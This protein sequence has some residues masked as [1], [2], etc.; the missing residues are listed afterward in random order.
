MKT[1]AVVLG[2]MIPGLAGCGAETAPPRDQWRI[3]AYTD[4][5]VP[6]F[7]EFLDAE[8]L[9]ADGTSCGGCSRELSAN[10]AS[11]WPVSFGVV[12][13]DGKEDLR[14]RLKLIRAS[15]DTPD[16]TA[17]DRVI[18]ALVHLPA[19]NG[20]TDV[21][22]VLTMDCFGVA[23]DPK[24]DRSCN[25]KTGSLTGA[26]SGSNSDPDHY[27]PNS[28]LEG[29]T[30]G[31]E[32]SVEKMQ[33]ISGG[34]FLMGS[35]T[36]LPD[37][38]ASPT[39]EQ[40]VQVSPF[41]FDTTEMTVAAYKSLVDQKM[42]PPP[43]MA[44]DYCTYGGD[45]DQMPMNCVTRAEAENACA[46]LGKRLP[47]EAEWEW[48]AGN[49]TI[50]SQYPWTADTQDLCSQAY[51]GLASFDDKFQGASSCDTPSSQA[52]PRTGFNPSD[53]TALEIFD[54]GGNVAEWVEDNFLPYDD[55]RCWGQEVTLHN[56]LPCTEVGSPV[57]RGGSW[58]SVPQNA[59]VTF[60]GTRSNA[61][62]VYG[63]IG[64]RCA[65]SAGNAPTQ[66]K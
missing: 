7:G 59:T 30:V 49:L 4:A 50:E 35:P 22:V 10:D 33:C 6:Q 39:P 58:R 48:A 19:P 66:R 37:A 25:P 40:L 2:L 3:V 55:A 63:E 5:Q 1:R 46:A 47:S 62:G 13:P 17:S 21:D 32:G 31:C 52:G 23:A 27:T 65:K 45:D 26:P 12:P 42:I 51:V 18:D 61:S 60:R 56:S 14:V 29:M 53:V 11:L 28:W 54:L 41:F 16:G 9:D 20:I 24:N 38:E 44:D 15:L 57:V 64:F 34:T 36:Y 8:I 43:N